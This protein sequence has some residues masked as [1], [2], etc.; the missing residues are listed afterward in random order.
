MAT[1]MGSWWWAASSQQRACSC[2]RFSHR[3]F[4]WNIKS[5][6]W[7]SPPTSQ[8]WH[9]VTYSQNYNC[10]WKGRDFRPSVRFRKIRHGKWWRMRELC[11]VPR[12]LLWRGRKCHCL[13]HN[14][15]C[16]LNVSI[17]ILHG[18]GWI[19]SGQHNFSS[20]MLYFKKCP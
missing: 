7:L 10:L 11:E 2:Y 9:P 15:S 12:C 8:I 4:L 6:R 3:V 19:L 1:I 13:M 5:P 14:V 16:I 17:F 20:Q 18:C